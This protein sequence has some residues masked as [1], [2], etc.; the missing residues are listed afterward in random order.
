MNKNNKT[1]TFALGILCIILAVSLVVVIATSDK[2]SNT[3]KTSDTSS[4]VTS[5]Q[6][7]V[8]SL[9]T[10]ISEYETQM[11]N[12]TSKNNVYASIIA[13]EESAIII[14][15]ETYTQDADE[16]SV[17][18][19]DKLNYAGYIEIQ[20]ESTSKTTYLQVSYTYNNLEFNQTVTVGNNGTAY[21]PILPGNIKIIL[22]NIDTNIDTET[23]DTIVRMIYIY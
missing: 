21:F 2:Q 9:N 1:V 13:L 14:S 16:T 6:N 11:G 18:F 10:K 4:Q 19:N 23:V 15:D 3:P 20:T 17:I 22:G 7:Q 8:N 12:L 5:L